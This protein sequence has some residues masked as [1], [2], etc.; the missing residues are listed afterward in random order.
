MDTVCLAYDSP[1][2]DVLYVT[3]PS[4]GNVPLTYGLRK[5]PTQGSH[6]MSGFSVSCCR[7]SRLRASS[8]RTSVQSPEHTLASTPRSRV[9]NVPERIAARMAAV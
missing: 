6:S 7:K 8:L 1:F 4:T 9:R 3:L 5:A 2:L